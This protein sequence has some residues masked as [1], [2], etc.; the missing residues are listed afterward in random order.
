MRQQF[1][2]SIDRMRADTLEDITQPFPGIDPLDLT[3]SEEGIHHG[4]SLSPLVGTGEQVVLAAQGQR[5]DGV[6]DEI[7]VDL[8]A[9]VVEVGGQQREL[10]FGVVQGFADGAF[11]QVVG[12]L[13]DDPLEQFSEDRPGFVI[14]AHLPGLVHPT[15]LRGTGA[16][17]RRAA[18]SNGGLARPSSG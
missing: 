1:V 18:G 10:L 17:E 2:E 12:L 9:T 4:G 11:A 14:T 8:Q 13:G 5:A 15:R 3:A 6:L 7:V 16:P